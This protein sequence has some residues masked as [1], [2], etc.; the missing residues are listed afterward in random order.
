LNSSGSGYISESCRIA[1]KHLNIYSDRQTTDVP[2]TV[3]AINIDF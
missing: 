3:F 2:R 1:Q